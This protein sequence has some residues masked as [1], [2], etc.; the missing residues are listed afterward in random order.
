MVQ[1]VSFSLHTPWAALNG[2]TLELAELCAAEF[3]EVIHVH[4]YVAGNEKVDVAVAVVVGPSGTGGEASALDS[5]FFG[6]VFECAVS[7]VAVKRIVAVSGDVEVEIAVVVV[8]GDG[9]AHA[10]AFVSESRFLG[11]VGELEVGILM[12]ECDEQIATVLT[13][14]VDGRSVDHHDVELAIVIAVEEADAPAHRFDDVMFVGGR[15]MG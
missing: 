7:L 6:D 13:I 2:N 8:I 3:G 4:V 10:P 11:D 15:N 1:E 9:N 5:C 12:P 14:A